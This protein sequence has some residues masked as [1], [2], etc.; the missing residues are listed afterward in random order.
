MTTRALRLRLHAPVFSLLLFAGCNAADSGNAVARRAAALDPP[1]LWL[2]E[3]LDG[4]GRATA[5]VR[6]CTDAVL[7]QGLARVRAEIDGEDCEM[8]GAPVEHDGLY[9][10]RC[11]LNGRRYGVTADHEGDRDRDFT[12]R[13]AVTALDAPGVQAVQVRRYRKIGPCPAG[14]RVG[15]EA[16]A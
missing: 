12:V 11:V 16:G 14:W 3:A 2:A 10:A 9:A 4:Q 7:Q 15:D 13:V 1:Q 6:L 8:I 5:S